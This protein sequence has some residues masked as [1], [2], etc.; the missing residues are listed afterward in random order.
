MGGPILSVLLAHAQ[1]Q[2]Q[3]Q[4]AAAAQSI[5]LRLCTNPPDHIEGAFF[6]HDYCSAY[7]HTYVQAILFW[8]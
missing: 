8:E 1:G 3:P 2:G 5:H 6:V 7:V 4:S